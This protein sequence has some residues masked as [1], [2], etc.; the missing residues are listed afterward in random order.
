LQLMANPPAG[1]AELIT[2]F[3]EKI[4]AHDQN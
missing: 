2:E 4:E 1:V 3:M